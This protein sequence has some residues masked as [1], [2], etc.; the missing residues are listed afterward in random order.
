[1]RMTLA[2][3]RRLATALV[4]ALAISTAARGQDSVMTAAAHIEAGE[5]EHVAMNA[6]AALA[7]YEAALELEPSNYDA[8][9]RA[10]REQVDVA[11]YMTDK[12]QRAELFKKAEAFARRAVEVNPADA[13]GHFHLARALG[14][15]ALSLGTRDRIRMAGIIREHALEA[16]RINPDH[17]GALHVMGVW[18]AE[19]MRLNGMSRFMARNFLG[20]KVFGEANWKS[21]VSYMEKSRDV[22]PERTVHRLDLARVYRDVDNHASARL[23][24]EQVLSMAATD[25]NDRHYKAEAAA[26]LKRLRTR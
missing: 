22:E 3:H 25:Y 13:E 15:T 4:A 11:E 5:R 7:H 6:P 23:E 18:N 9:W 10:A 20:G 26:E 2:L 14:R 17:P 12:D 21:A 16:L 8:L 24:Y 19:I 1:M